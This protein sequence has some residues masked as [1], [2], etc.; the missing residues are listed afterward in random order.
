MRLSIEV[1]AAL[2]PVAVACGSSSSPQAGRASVPAA[3]VAELHPPASSVDPEEARRLRERTGLLLG[4]AFELR[5]A[6]GG[7]CPTTQQVLSRYAFP[8]GTESDSKGAPFSI[9]CSGSEIR[10]VD[11]GHGVV[12][13]V[14]YTRYVPLPDPGP[15]PTVESTLRGLERPMMDCARGRHPDNPNEFGKLTVRWRPT[16][17]RCHVTVRSEGIAASK[18]VECVK[19]LLEGI[20][21]CERLGGPIPPDSGMGSFPISWIKN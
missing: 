10:L 12:D 20:D 1:I 13:A 11:S 2:A 14:K 19:G 18:I 21:F 16:E 6:N 9:E 7:A 3:T 5:T 17:D 15:P 4:G 8:P